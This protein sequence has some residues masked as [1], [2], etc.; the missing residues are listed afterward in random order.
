[1][2]KILMAIMAIFV[3]A[4]VGAV[5]AIPAPMTMVSGQVTDASNAPVAS[6]NV[7]VTCTHNSVATTK[8]VVTDASGKYYAFFGSTECNTGDSVVAKTSGA[9]DQNG[10]VIYNKSCRINTLK[11]N[12]QI[13]EFG[14]IAGALALIAGVGIVAYRRK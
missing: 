4:L 9:D 10:V 2:K 14:V 3:L 1:M 8:D 13:P 5:S 6:A 12:L 11:I 7:A